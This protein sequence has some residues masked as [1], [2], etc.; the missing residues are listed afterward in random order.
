MVITLFQTRSRSGLGICEGGKDCG[1]R[2]SDT[3]NRVNMLQNGIPKESLKSPPSNQ[4][5]IINTIKAAE[6]LLLAQ[7]LGEAEVGTVAPQHLIRGCRI[8]NK[9]NNNPIQP[10]VPPSVR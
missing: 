1:E 6:K 3:P 8:S 7:S 4:K 9:N 2:F 10:N 5:P